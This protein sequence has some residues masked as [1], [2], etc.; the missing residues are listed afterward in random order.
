MKDLEKTITK[1][2][3]NPYNFQIRYKCVRI[4]FTKTFTY[5]IHFIIDENT[6]FISKVL[7]TKR[8]FE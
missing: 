6:T 7:H 1:I 4:T 3:K 5:G 2:G 8:F